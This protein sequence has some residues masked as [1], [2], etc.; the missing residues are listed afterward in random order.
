MAEEETIRQEMIDA[1]VQDLETWNPDT[2][3]EFAQEMYRDELNGIE[4][5]LTVED[6]N[7]PLI[8]GIQN[9]LNKINKFL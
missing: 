4:E 9:V 7:L 6:E 1:I 8:F 2:I 3:L 5:R